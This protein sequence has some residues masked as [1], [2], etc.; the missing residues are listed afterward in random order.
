M[1]CT[2]KSTVRGIPRYR[3]KPTDKRCFIASAIYGLDAPETARLRRFRDEV[4]LENFAGKWVVALYY[5]ISP[6]IAK[7]LDHNQYAREL[8]KRVLD[9]VVGALK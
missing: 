6:P 4:L 3:V 7:M 2:I 9:V 8:I 5:Q 1:R